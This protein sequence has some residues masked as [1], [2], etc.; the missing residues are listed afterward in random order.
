MSR[1]VSSPFL[2]L[3]PAFALLYMT[4]CGGSNPPI[5]PKT[6]SSI[7]VTAASSSIGVGATDQFKATG[8][9]SD[10]SSQE[11]AGVT[12]T[13]SS[14]AAATISTA[15]VAKAVAIGKTN[16]IASSGMVTSPPFSLTVT[17]TTLLS[18]A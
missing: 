7:A 18:I 3:L 8:T 12:W 9:Y 11:L 15:G 14:T 5:T 16:I 17:P 2:F 6:L 13:S 10:Q 4:G 1:F